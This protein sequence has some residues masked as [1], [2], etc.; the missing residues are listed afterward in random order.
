MRLGEGMDESQLI[1]RRTAPSVSRL[2]TSSCGDSP[3]DILAEKFGSAACTMLMPCL[4]AKL[5]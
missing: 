1:W 3:F 5:E 2:G 4:R